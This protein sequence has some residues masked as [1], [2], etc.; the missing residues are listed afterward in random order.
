[1][2]ILLTGFEPNDDG[3]NASEILI[4][5]LKANPT[6][7]IIDELDS[8]RFE[9]MPG[10]TNQLEISLHQLIVRTAGSRIGVM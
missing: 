5:S 1:M 10:N 4:R 2:K 8:L 6:P 9:V 7:E 3:L